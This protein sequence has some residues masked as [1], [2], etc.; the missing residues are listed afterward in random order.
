MTSNAEARWAAEALVLL[1]DARRFL[2]SGASDPH[3]REA[4]LARI[5]AHARWVL[6]EATT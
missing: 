3:E 1:R 6:T 4:L 5:E 2:A